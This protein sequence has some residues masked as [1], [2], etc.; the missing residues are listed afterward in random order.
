MK[1]TICM[2]LAPVRDTFNGTHRRWNSAFGLCKA[3]AYG[4]CSNLMHFIRQPSATLTE[5]NSAGNF[6]SGTFN[7]FHWLSTY[8]FYY[9]HKQ[10]RLQGTLSLLFP[11]SDVTLLITIHNIKIPEAPGWMRTLNE[12]KVLALLQFKSPKWLCKGFTKSLLVSYW[13]K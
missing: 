2:S 6:V 10:S 11:T 12:R 1:V 4:S 7:G 8:V 9:L 3:L 5:L 13:S